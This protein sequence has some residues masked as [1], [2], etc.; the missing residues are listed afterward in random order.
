MTM[1]KGNVGYLLAGVLF[2]VLILS[3]F[4]REMGREQA[5]GLLMTPEEVKFV[6][7]KPQLDNIYELT[8]VT[9]D[10]R[11]ELRFIGVN[12]RIYLNHVNW[13]SSS[14]V[15]DIN[16]VSKELLSDAVK[17]GYLPQCLDD[18]AR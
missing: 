16:K 14:G 11:V 6:C 18:A 15:G 2:T 8:Y 12:H 9:G 7:G 10:R 5:S 3:P 13:T 4:L 17:R 1:I